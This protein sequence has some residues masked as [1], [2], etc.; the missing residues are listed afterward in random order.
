V[1]PAEIGER[2]PRVSFKAFTTYTPAKVLAVTLFEIKARYERL[3][4]LEPL[5]EELPPQLS[6]I[7]VPGSRN[8]T[9]IRI[10]NLFKPGT[11]TSCGIIAWMQE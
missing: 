8:T 1:L 10:E 11:P 9:R 2:G 5:L 7:K 4:V 6:H 3:L